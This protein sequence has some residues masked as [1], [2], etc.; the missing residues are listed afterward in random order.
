MT[1]QDR[2]IEAA[3]KRVGYYQ[4]KL[5]EASQRL[6]AATNATN[7]EISEAADALADDLDDERSS[8]FASCAPNWDA[9]VAEQVLDNREWEEEQRLQAEAETRSK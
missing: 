2:R 8:E 4:T 5:E 6:L 3:R 7:I 9:M 1:R